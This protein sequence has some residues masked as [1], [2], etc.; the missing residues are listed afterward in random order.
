M[1]DM[2]VF[3]DLD[4]FEHAWI[5][6]GS[7]VAVGLLAMAAMAVFGIWV[8]LVV[9]LLGTGLAVSVDPSVWMPDPRTPHTP[10]G[11]VRQGRSGPRRSPADMPCP[12]Q[13]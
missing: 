7:L 12:A 13:E 4:G 8:S 3:A 5:A 2:D 1:D 6:A 10:R 11:G 9:L